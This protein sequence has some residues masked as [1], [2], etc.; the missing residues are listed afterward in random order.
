MGTRITT[1]CSI[2]KEMPR[3]QQTG[4]AFLNKTIGIRASMSNRR[5]QKE[6]YK[7][8]SVSSNLTTS[9]FLTDA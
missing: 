9:T 2:N 5:E 8:W 4:G 7:T 6:V 3:S 1:S